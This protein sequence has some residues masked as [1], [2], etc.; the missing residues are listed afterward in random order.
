MIVKLRGAL[1]DLS[2]FN[3][4][5]GPIS[6]QLAEDRDI[7][8]MF[9]LHHP[10][11]SDEKLGS[12][13]EKYRVEVDDSI[14]TD[15]TFDLD[16]DA[17]F[18]ARI[19]DVLRQYKKKTGTLHATWRK[20]MELGIFFVLTC[21]SIYWMVC[22]SWIALFTT[23]LLIWLFSVNSFH[24]GSHFA[25]SSNWRINTFFTYICPI[26]SSPLM[27]Y[28]QHVIGHHTYPNVIGKDPDLYHSP[29]VVRHTEDIR[30]RSAH[31]IQHW[32]WWPLTWMASVWLGIHWTNVVKRYQG[33][34]G[35]NKVV[36]YKPI[37][38]TRWQL[39]IAG[40]FLTTLVL[41]G[42]PFLTSMSWTKTI[43][44]SVLPMIQYSIYFML[45]TQINHLVKENLNVFDKNI[46]KQQILTS[47]QVASDSYIVYLFTGGLNLQ[48]M[49]HLFPYVSHDHLL[50][51]QPEIKEICKEFNVEWNESASMWEAVTRYVSHLKDL[52]GTRKA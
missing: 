51:M 9:Q 16:E 18:T 15:N 32:F 3:H 39:H 10:L 41:F 13:L 48:I 17:Q 25:L 49:H 37:S 27:W 44:F 20:W 50:A 22:G 43:I 21:L 28:H 7:T 36:K 35:Y 33:S 30:H 12:I 34:P 19:T 14:P 47:H 31:S 38:D 42:W 23:P 2:R 5:G 26:F 40:R 46:Y 45:C 52:S 11:M 1:Y 8:F 6:L 4:P 29:A 24:D